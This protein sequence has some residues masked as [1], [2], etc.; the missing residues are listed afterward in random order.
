VAGADQIFR[1]AAA[2][3]PQSDKTYFHRFLPKD[4]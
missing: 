1:H 3:D 2:H 4:D